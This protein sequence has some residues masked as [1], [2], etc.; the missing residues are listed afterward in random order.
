VFKTRCCAKKRRLWQY[1]G[2]AL[3]KPQKSLKS[4]K[5]WVKNLTLV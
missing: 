3:K 1:I 2:K 4:F 5:K